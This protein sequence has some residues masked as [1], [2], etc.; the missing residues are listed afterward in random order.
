MHIPTLKEYHEMQEVT[1]YERQI[2]AWM[3]SKG[4]EV[5]V[6]TAIAKKFNVGNAAMLTLLNELAAAGKIRRAARRN[7]KNAAAFYIPS[8]AELDAERRMTQEAKVTAP[9]KIDKVRQELY[10]QIAASRAAMPSKG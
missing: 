3:R 8:E 10:A 6:A 9:L 1:S 7:N 4:G 2:L 5:V